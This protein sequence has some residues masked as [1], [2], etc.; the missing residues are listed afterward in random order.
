MMLN[1]N[2]NE[3]NESACH[4]MEKVNAVE[5]KSSR[6]KPPI[7]VHKKQENSLQLP[8]QHITNTNSNGNYIINNDRLYFDDFHS[9]K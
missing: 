9:H 8:L 3:V 1:A 6:T 4:D 2:D 5:P 7:T